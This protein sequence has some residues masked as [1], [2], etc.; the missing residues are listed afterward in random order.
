MRF[1][2]ILTLLLFNQISPK[3]TRK[4]EYDYSSYKS[5][6]H[7]QNLSSQQ[8]TSSSTDESA[9]YIDGSDKITVTD[10]TITKESGNSSNIENSEFYGVNAAVL[11][12]G[13]NLEIT[14]GEIITKDQGGNSIVA[15]NDGQV[16]V[17]GTVITSTGTRSA[18]G[19]HAT[20][21]GNIVG[22]DVTI[23][24]VGGSCATLATDRGEGVV[25]CKNCNLSTKGAGSPIIYSTGNIKIEGSTGNS[26]GAQAV[27]IEGKNT[28]EVKGN[29]KLKCTA[30]P[31]RE[32]IDQCGVMIYQSFSGDAE[33]GTGNF[34]CS[35]SSIEIVSS[36]SYYSTAPMFFVTNTKANIALEGCQF[37]YGSNTF[38]SAKGTSAWGKS[39]SNGGDV[40]LTLT[41]ENI[42]GNFVLDKISSLSLKLVN[43]TI[44]GTINGDKAAKKL[45][46]EMDVDSQI[47]LTGDSYY[48][49]FKNEDVNGKNLINGSYSWHYQ[50]TSA[51]NI[52]N[53]SFLLYILLLC[54]LLF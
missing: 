24:T 41:N 30:S 42:E 27:V 38:L 9:V 5:V 39:G 36:S 50:S 54:G 35:E 7:N 40:T 11:V 51:A 23:N 17:T 48:S 20:Y 2:L 52:L 13:G 33:T 12:Q 45:A 26:E 46:I 32:K 29:S 49:E 3:F 25:S 15:T 6:S 4:S 31:N 14:R 1:L 10:S 21:G 18:R 43:S 16:K 28:A 47:T 22:E 53:A 19:L 44:K 37:T 34:V 8:V